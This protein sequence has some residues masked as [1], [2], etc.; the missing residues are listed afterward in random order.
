MHTRHVWHTATALKMFIITAF[1]NMQ[2]S[3][4][5]QKRR[6]LSFL[7]GKALLLCYVSGQRP[8]PPPTAARSSKQPP[9]TTLG[10]TPAPHKPVWFPFSFLPVFFMWVK[11]IVTVF[12]QPLCKSSVSLPLDLRSSKAFSSRLVWLSMSL[13][14]HQH[15]ERTRPNPIT[16][17]LFRERRATQLRNP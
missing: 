1:M 5:I 4:S 3:R 10:A 2:R 9:R 14:F 6:R 17:W 8:L 12:Y 16:T 7:N 11:Y 15:L 13:C